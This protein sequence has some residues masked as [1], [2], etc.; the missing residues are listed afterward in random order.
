MPSCL[1][2]V[3]ARAKVRVRVRVLGLGLGLANPNPNPY[4]NLSSM[5]AS[6][7]FWLYLLGMLRTI[8]VVRW[9][10]PMRTRARL[11]AYSMR[12]WLGL[13]VGLGLGLGLGLGSGLGS[14][15][16]LACLLAVVRPPPST[17][18]A[19]AGLIVGLG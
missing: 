9:S 10:S 12:S 3:G 8:S 15:S 17:E 19:A 13:G 5:V 7:I 1:V 11:S 14:G 4:A 18:A 6:S 2:R 16:G